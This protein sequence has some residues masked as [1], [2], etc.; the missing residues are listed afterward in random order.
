MING[1][2]FSFAAWRLFFLTIK[3][4]VRLGINL[5]FIHFQGM[6]IVGDLFGAGKMFLP[7]V[8][9]PACLPACRCFLFPYVFPHDRLERLSSLLLQPLLIAFLLLGGFARVPRGCSCRLAIKMVPAMMLKL[10]LHR[11]PC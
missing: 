4:N 7:Q 2:R 6:G 10:D 8:S 11:I 3:R 1:Q 5:S 9:W